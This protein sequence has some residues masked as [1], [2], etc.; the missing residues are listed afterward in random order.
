MLYSSEE[1][2]EKNGFRLL[3]F[4]VVGS[5]SNDF[6][7]L[8]EERSILRRIL[9]LL[10]E[11]INYTG[12]VLSPRKLI[13]SLAF[14]WKQT[15]RKL[16][17]EKSDVKSARVK[18]L[19]KMKKQEK[20]SNVY[21]DKTYLHS[22]SLS[23]KSWTDSE[24]T[25]LKK[26]VSKGQRVIVVNAGGGIGLYSKCAVDVKCKMR[27]SSLECRKVIITTIWNTN[28]SGFNY[29]LFKVASR[30]TYT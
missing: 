28:K 2:A 14:G 15:N 25:G 26:P 16:L 18:Y 21:G 22:S 4:C 12:S 1:T 5:V 10:R 30:K 19:R 29:S 24:K 7:N 11:F 6:H 3:W 13:H 20:R 9:R 17:I 8:E 23:E 27:C